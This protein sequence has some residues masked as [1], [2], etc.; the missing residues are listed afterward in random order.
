M[1]KYWKK[2]WTHEGL[3]TKEKNDDHMKAHVEKGKRKKGER[4]SHVLKIKLKREITHIK[5]YSTGLSSFYP[6]TCTS[7]SKGMTSFLLGSK[8]WL[9]KICRISMPS[10]LSLTKSN[11]PN[12]LHPRQSFWLSQKA[13]DRV[14]PKSP[15][16]LREARHRSTLYEPSSSHR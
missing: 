3:S 1:Q 2:I 8:L 11:N 16:E 14:T 7:W 4:D 5:E 12:L 6:Y 13:T 10:Y 15:N 9:N